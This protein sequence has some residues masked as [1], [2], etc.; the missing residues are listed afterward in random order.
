MSLDADLDGTGTS[1]CYGIHMNLDKDGITASGKTSRTYGMHIDL[2]DSV[3]NVGTAITYGIA[4]TNNFAN[5]GDGTTKAYGLYTKVGGADT[6]YDIYMENSADS[7]EYAGFRVSAGGALAV[8]TT[9]DDAT[10]H[11]TLEPDGYVNVKNR[12]W[13]ATETTNNVCPSGDVVYMGVN[14]TGDGAT[15]AG[16]IVYLDEDGEWQDAQANA[17]ST[18]TNL[19]GIALGTNP[20]T[21]GVLLRGTFVLDHDVG[22]NQGVPL[23][24]S[25]TSAGD[26]TATLPDSNN[27]V[28]RIIGYNLNDDDLIWFNP[29]NTWVVITA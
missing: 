2:D 16:N 19:L 9:S 6:N 1:I 5:A 8:T 20:L 24:L 4:I 15:T 25:D 22:N 12:G 14:P 27:D 7:S 28:V 23:Y 17:E 3:N 13:I 18:S 11:I 26:A 21:D 29:D 10:G